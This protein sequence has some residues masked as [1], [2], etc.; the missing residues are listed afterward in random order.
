VAE[1]ARDRWAGWLPERREA[2]MGVLIPI[3]DR[4]LHDVALLDG[5]IRRDAFACP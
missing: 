4:V 1:P 2:T 5:G 3:R